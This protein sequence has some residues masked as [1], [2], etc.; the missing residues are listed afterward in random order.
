MDST[1]PFEGAERRSLMS[2]FTDLWRETATLVHEEAELAKAE[3]SEK[4]SQFGTGLAAILVGG[5]IVFSGFLVLL[6]AA[7][8]ALYMMMS[9]DHRIWIAPLVVGLVVAVL[10]FIALAAGRRELKARNLA[11]EKTIDSMQ[12]NA[13]LVKGHVQ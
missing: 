8:G 5:A 4:V 10:G 13:E 11:P 2:L 3:M 7:V 9:T 1:T 6:G 12:R